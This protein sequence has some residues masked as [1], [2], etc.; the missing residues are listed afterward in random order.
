[1]AYLMSQGLDLMCLHLFNVQRLL[2]FV[3][4][5]GSRESYVDFTF[6]VIEKYA[7]LKEK[8]KLFIVMTMGGGKTYYFYVTVLK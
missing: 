3:L 8:K 2:L 5:I 6:P 7:D 1:M 4:Y